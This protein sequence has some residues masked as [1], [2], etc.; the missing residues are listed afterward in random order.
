[1]GWSKKLT[2]ESVLTT[3]EEA[4]QYEVLL[5]EDDKDIVAIVRS[6][7]DHPR[8]RITV[9]TDGAE[10]LRAFK[11]SP[12]DLVLMDIHMPVL[13]GCATTL[14]IRRW[15]IDNSR[16]PTPITALTASS[17]AAELGRIFASGCTN[18]LPKPITKPMLLQAVRQ[19]LGS[20]RK[21]AVA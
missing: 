3:H 7:V 1:M 2:L 15:E 4:P 20:P 21:S 6:Y 16:V 8:I 5:V 13:D 9:A 19:F 18:Y 12:Y 14:A 10:G 11:C 17:T